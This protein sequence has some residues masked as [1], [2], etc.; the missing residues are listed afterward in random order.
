MRVRV[1]IYFVFFS[2]FSLGIL[3]I[4]SYLNEILEKKIAN[5][6]SSYISSIKIK[7]VGDIF[8]HNSN[9]EAA[10]TNSGYDFS[11]A[12]ENVSVPLTDADITS[13]WLGG[14]FDSAG[15]YAGYPLFKSP[16]EL[17]DALKESGFDIML[18][19][20]HTYD[21]NEAGLISTSGNIKKRGLIQL[22]AYASEEESE[23]IFTFS[24]DSLTLSMI[25]YTYWLNGFKAKKPWQVSLID[26]EKIAEDIKKAKTVSDFVIV[27][28]HYGTEYSRE[29]SEYQ[30]KIARFCAE[31]GAGII[32]GSHPHV[33]EPVET[34]ITEDGRIVYSAYSLGNFFC[35]QRERYTDCGVILSFFVEKSSRSN[36]KAIVKGLSYTPTYVCK[37]TE[38]GNFKYKIVLS[39]TFADTSDTMLDRIILESLS[40][41]RDI[42]KL[43]SDTLK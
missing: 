24:K 36:S 14:V 17:L 37:Y 38:N 9:L 23:H 42:L 27:F 40:D 28:L 21:Y 5:E 31:K 16:V 20:N 32:I 13:C 34:I 25:S 4:D 22:G 15:P 33:I 8:L 19:T 11:S 30:R 26:T 18:R 35:G 29:P 1:I 2:C 3:F 10:K 12:F 7:C 43:I 41:T 6:K 39:Q